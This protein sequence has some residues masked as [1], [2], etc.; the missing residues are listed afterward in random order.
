MYAN[1]HKSVM[2]LQRFVL[3]SELVVV[4]ARTAKGALV[5]NVPA[6]YV[7]F[8]KNL[9]AYFSAARSGL[10]KVPGITEKQ[11][12]LAGGMSPAA[13]EWIEDSGWSVHIDTRNPRLSKP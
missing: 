3:V 7:S 4:A 11:L 12:W 8:T 5:V 9:A 1:Y 10:D 2:P 13:R 6:D